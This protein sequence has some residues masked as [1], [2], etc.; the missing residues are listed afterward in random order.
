MGYVYL[1]LTVLLDT[2]GIAFLNKANGV[3]NL[4]YLLLGLLFIN[5]GLVSLSVA[6][7]TLEMTVAN[8]LFA[9]LTSLLVAMIGYFYFGERY[10][11]LQYGFIIAIVISVIGLHLTGLSE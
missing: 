11:V 8:T 9:G 5:L 7:K 2:V 6:F 3:S 1:T 10:S 4:K